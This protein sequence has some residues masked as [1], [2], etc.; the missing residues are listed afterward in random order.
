MK[1]RQE[2]FDIDTIHV[3]IA[4]SVVSGEITIREAAAE[5]YKAGWTSYIDEEYTQRKVDEYLKGSESV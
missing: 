4:K 1:N 5:F 2:P 3:S